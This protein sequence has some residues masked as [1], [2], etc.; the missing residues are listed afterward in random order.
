MVKRGPNPLVG[1]ALHDIIR[2][3]T[4]AY[5]TGSLHA[6]NRALLLGLSDQSK[7]TEEQKNIL[8]QLLQN[9]GTDV[10]L[11][12]SDL[13]GDGDQN[14]VQG[15]PRAQVFREI[16]EIGADVLTH[17]YHPQYLL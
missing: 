13:Y 14:P 10:A 4:R 7:P 5:S 11:N 1:N 16:W 3:T 17:L 15:E 2:D 6:E 12:D 8:R 9:V